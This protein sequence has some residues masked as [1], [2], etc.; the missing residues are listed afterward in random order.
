MGYSNH[1]R[2]IVREI[3]ARGI[4]LAP[5]KIIH[6]RLVPRLCVGETPPVSLLI[7]QSEVPSPSSYPWLHGAT[8]IMCTPLSFALARL[9]D[10]LTTTEL[11]YILSLISQPPLSLLS[12]VGRARH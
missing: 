8:S 11:I 9:W 10:H 4:Q 3:G 2:R 7:R 1:R 5:L 6:D 12:S